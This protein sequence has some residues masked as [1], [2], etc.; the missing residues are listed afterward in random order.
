MIARLVLNTCTQC[1]DPCRRI[2]KFNTLIK[3]NMN[4]FAIMNPG[5]LSLL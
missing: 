4:L 2:H 3:K 5:S 1:G